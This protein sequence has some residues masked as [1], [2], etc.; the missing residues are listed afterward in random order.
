MIEVHGSI[1]TSSCQ[2]CGTEFP[3]EEVEAL[4]DEDGCRAL[5]DRCGAR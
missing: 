1:R 5:L 3:L 4:F 2:S